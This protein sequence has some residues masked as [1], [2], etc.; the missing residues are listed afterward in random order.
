MKKT[1]FICL[2]LFFGNNILAQEPTPKNS[3]Q[4]LYQNI[5]TF[6]KDRKFF[7]FFH[8]LI[9][10]KI[11]SPE[12]K[13]IKGITTH[14]SLKEFECKII[15]NINIETLD[16]FGYSVSDTNQTPT[17][18]FEKL[19][20]SLH[21][22]TRKSIIKNQLL[23]KNN[24]YLDTLLIKENER[25]LRNNR[26]IRSA[27]ITPVLI[28]KNNDSVDVYVRVLDTWSIIPT[29]AISSSKGN[30]EM[31]E[32]NFLG[33]GHEVSYNYIKRFTDSKYAY[34][35]KYLINN[36]F[37][38]FGRI[39]LQSN[40]D[41]NSRLNQKVRIERP[42]YSVYAKWAGGA[43]YDFDSYKQLFE[44]QT[45]IATSQNIKSQNFQFWLGHSFRIDDEKNEDS[46]HTNL[47]IT[48]G[49][50]QLSY[51][52]RPETN[53]YITQYFNNE[54]MYL[55]TIGINTQKYFQ[56][57]YLFRFGSVEDVPY[58][59]IIA[60]TGGLQNKLNRNRSYFA[61]KFGYADYYNFGY[62]QVGFQIGSYFNQG[63]TE[64]TTTIVEGNYFTKHFSWGSWRFRQFVKPVLT[65]GYNRLA[66][67]SDRI[68][69]NQNGIVGLNNSHLGKNRLVITFQTQSYNPKTWLGFNLSPYLNYSLGFLSSESSS[70][71]ASKMYS[72]IGLGLLI[73]NDYLVFN[74]FQISFSFY[75]T[76]PDG[77][78]NI[79]KTN[80]INNSNINFNDFYIGQ[81]TTI[82]YQ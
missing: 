29:G 35:A 43:Y 7:K 68:S 8:R 71:L 21:I 51:L 20:N 47:I 17:N 53:V 2:F 27:K 77:T 73:T 10:R 56:D 55:T 64:Q 1:I 26:Y 40:L 11:D 25:V 69:L 75:P 54:I 39:E 41:L 82:S 15:R 23:F 42:F 50:T 22:K 48:A 4:K 65:L 9:F 62:L 72:Q 32:R 74:N 61:S 6:S 38:S 63:K 70:L 52:Q 12:K 78:N 28:E 16:P 14:T 60:V 76:M 44:N 45:A 59:K 34:N 18:N 30:I 37:N 5:S 33:I 66:V 31:T 36:V 24:D 79:I 80:A 49:I 58:G 81:P 46:R 19:G 3:D 57:E 13:K 67:N